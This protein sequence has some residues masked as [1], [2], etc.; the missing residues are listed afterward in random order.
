MPE[1]LVGKELATAFKTAMRAGFSASDLAETYCAYMPDHARDL[2]AKAAASDLKRALIEV[3]DIIERPSA[4]G[5]RRAS[6]EAVYRAISVCLTP[7]RNGGRV[8]GD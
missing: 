5:E 3:L 2:V 8:V 4:V 7:S 6:V 1:K